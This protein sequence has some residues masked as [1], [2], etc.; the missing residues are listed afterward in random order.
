MKR[1][2]VENDSD[3]SIAWKLFACVWII[4]I[5]FAWKETV[6]RWSISSS[7]LLAI[8]IGTPMYRKTFRME[9]RQKS[10]NAK[11]KDSWK[12]IGQRANR[13]RTTTIKTASTGAVQFLKV[14]FTYF[15]LS[16]RCTVFS[17]ILLFFSSVFL[18]LSLCRVFFLHFWL[19]FLS[20]RGVSFYIC[21]DFSHSVQCFCFST[22][23]S[24]ICDSVVHVLMCQRRH[25]EWEIG[26]NY[27]W[28]LKRIVVHWN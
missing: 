9:T 22:G 2:R 25:R 28:Q 11:W 8:T 26:R 17:C 3:S 10:S 7:S 4:A 24:H 21:S 13:K 6:G 19:F 18:Y 12:L 5:Q 15:R 16:Y 14:I 27:R 20:F 1:K 23:F